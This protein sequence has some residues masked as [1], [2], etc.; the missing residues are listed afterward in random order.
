MNTA[1]HD[2]EFARVAE[3][4]RHVLLDFDGPVCKI[5]AGLPAPTITTQLTAIV[6]ENGV[7]VPGEVRGPHGVLQ[8]AATVSQ[9]LAHQVEETLRVAEINAAASAEPTPGFDELLRV[10]EETGRTV[11]IVSNNADEAVN[12]YLTRAD[13]A[14]HVAHVEARD[15]NDHPVLMKPDPYLITRTVDFLDADVAT[16]ALVGDS[17][18]DVEAA[19]VAGMPCIGYANKPGKREGLTEAGADTII[20]RM[21]DLAAVLSAHR[22]RALPN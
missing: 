3:H 20:D 6:E 4:M 15:A 9:D 12:A 11:A 22:V 13:L 10:C 2:S 5:F 1:E 17:D 7:D 14:R 19:H 16:C 8:F 21:T 18:T